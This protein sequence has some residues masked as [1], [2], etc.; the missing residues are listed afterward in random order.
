LLETG[1]WKLERKRKRKRKKKRKE[2]RRPPLALGSW[3]L[4]RPTAAL[5]C[6]PP[7]PETTA[8]VHGTHIYLDALAKEKRGRE[9]KSLLAF[10]MCFR[11]SAFGAGVGAARGNASTS[12][13][14]N[15]LTRPSPF[16]KARKAAVVD[17]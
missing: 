5:K 16:P 6:I 17:G 4:G 10:N 12:R 13:S 9:E 11:I 7:V 3:A 8:Q 15:L 14:A 1:N 2:E